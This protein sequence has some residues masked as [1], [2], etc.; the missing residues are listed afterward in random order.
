MRNLALILLLSI[1][2]ASG[3]SAF[4]LYN[5]VAVISP[6]AIVSS[7]T[8]QTEIKIVACEFLPKL[9]SFYTA[10]GT[11]LSLL[12]GITNLSD[13]ADTFA[14]SLED[15]KAWPMTF[16]ADIGPL[17]SGETAYFLLVI[18]APQVKPNTSNTMLLTATPASDELGADALY[19]ITIKKGK[20]K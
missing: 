15:D 17:A 18:A 1:L 13:K 12:I 14:L 11:E 10:P 6:N 20:R 8:V 19:T 4:M 5:V 9:A 7:N 16:P 3:A 2:V